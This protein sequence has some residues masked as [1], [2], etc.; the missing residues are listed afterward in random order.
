MVI[1]PQTIDQKQEEHPTMN[2][3]K[4]TLES[5]GRISVPNL[6]A[7]WLPDLT[8]KEVIKGSAYTISG[9]YVG[10]EC[11]VPKLKRIMAHDAAELM[12]EANHTADDPDD[13]E[14]EKAQESE[15]D[16]H[17]KSAE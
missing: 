13:E 10:T 4:F 14:N 2:G 15:E 5:D 12:K 7:Y 8:I 3:T 1:L 6:S 16:L 11:I 17:D 9:E